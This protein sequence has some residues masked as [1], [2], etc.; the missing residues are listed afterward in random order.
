MIES[1]QLTLIDAYLSP[2]AALDEG[3][4]FNEEQGGSDS[5]HPS[6]SQGTGEWFGLHV[7]PIGL[8]LPTNAARELLN[9]PPV[10]RLPHTPSWLAGL[11]NVRGSLVP[12]VDT[13]HA[14]DLEHDIATRRYLL[15]FHQGEEMIGLLVDGLPRRQNFQN[16]ERMSSLP[17][18]PSALTGLIAGAYGREGRLWFEIDIENFFRTL[19]VRMSQV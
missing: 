16:H 17:P 5:T 10:A 9:P 8:L 15:I 18:H 7:G 19:V 2:V 4:I 11:I 1:T 3:M 14:L 13:A 6:Q 12:V